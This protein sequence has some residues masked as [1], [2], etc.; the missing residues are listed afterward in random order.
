MRQTDTPRFQQERKEA[1]NWDLLT[2]HLADYYGVPESDIHDLESLTEGEY[3]ADAYAVYEILDFGG[4]DRLVDLGTKHVHVE[5][6]YRKIGGSGLD[7]SLRTD[8][9]VDGRPAKFDK[10]DNAY[11]TR[12]YY[13]SVTAF[14]HWE[15]TLEVFKTVWLLDNEVI[16]DAIATG[17]INPVEHTNK[18]DD[19]GTAAQYVP[20]AELDSIG[21]VLDEWHGVGVEVE[22]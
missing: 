18:Q 20:V 9:G 12:G 19:D 7:F 14:G 11:Q 17:E 16:L 8:T 5:Q 3:N 13:P 15:P 22:R 10:W 1:V 2:P 6:R 21:A 4:L